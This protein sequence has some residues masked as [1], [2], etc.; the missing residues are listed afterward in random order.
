[1]CYLLEL[2]AFGELIANLEGSHI[3]SRWCEFD[4]KKSGCESVYNELERTGVLRG[5]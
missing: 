5:I 2:D 1:M 3:V 4:G